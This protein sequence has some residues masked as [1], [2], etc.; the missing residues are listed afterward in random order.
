[1]GAHQAIV[2]PSSRQTTLDA[3]RFRHPDRLPLAKG[4]EADIVYV[5]HKPAHDFVAEKPGMDEWGCV[6]RSLHPELGDKGQVVEHPLADWGQ[7][8]GYRFPDPH[9]AGRFDGV[10]QQ[11]ERYHR[12]GKF[13]CGS[14]GSGPL[15]MLDYLRGFEN[16]LVDVA[17]EPQRT[18]L[19]LDGVFG[20]LTG[21]S[22][23]L[24]ACGADAIYWADDQATQQGPLFSMRIWRELFA[25]RYR[26]LCTH[27][28][29]LGMVAYMHTCG[30]L[31]QHLADLVDC[32][33]DIIDNKQPAAW[34]DS[35]A[36]AG[37]RGRVAFST[38]IDIQTTIH[39]IADDQIEAEVERLV[40][41]L[42]TPAGGFIAT[43]Y[44]QPD[45]GL[46]QHKVARMWQAFQHFR[47]DSAEASE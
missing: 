3:I 14:C 28:H 9:A 17:T 8:E 31:S 10:A 26:A 24:A 12:D 40:R 4:A 13:V 19:L 32:G 7:C 16:Y 6:W 35:P 44:H 29:A 1:M 42:S 23:H 41:T 15:H 5:A 36:V 47:W 46:P 22:E 27:I 2:T 39:E 18:I 25:P 30:N 43:Y 38:C 34:M 33:V 45:L 20:F 11:I 37:V 21:L